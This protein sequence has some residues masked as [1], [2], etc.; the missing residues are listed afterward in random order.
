MR[1]MA[2]GDADHEAEVRKQA[3]IEANIV[4]DQDEPKVAGETAEQPDAAAAPEDQATVT[5]SLASDAKAANG[6]PLVELSVAGIVLEPGSE[7][8]VPASVAAVFED[9][10]RV[11]VSD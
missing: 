6:E 11:E 9:D 2:F 3:D 7:Q 8:E 4:S 5:V 10:D 1:R